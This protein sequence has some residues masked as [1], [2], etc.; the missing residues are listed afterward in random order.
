[1]NQWRGLKWRLIH[2]IQALS[3]V[4]HEARDVNLL[5]ITS[6]KVSSSEE[7]ISTKINAEL[8]RICFDLCKYVCET[9][10]VA[11]GLLVSVLLHT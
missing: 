9:R 2:V 7:R 5:L 10:R 4:Y 6:E 1:M 11:A 3:H 8:F